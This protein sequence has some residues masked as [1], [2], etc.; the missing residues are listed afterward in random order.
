MVLIELVL[1]HKFCLNSRSFYFLGD[2]I[3]D[4]TVWNSS[5]SVLLHF[6]HILPSCHVCLTSC[7]GKVSKIPPQK[8]SRLVHQFLLQRPT[9]A[10]WG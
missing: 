5:K 1:N 7:S 2:I 4:Q 9:S 8:F 10:L 3:F 6:L